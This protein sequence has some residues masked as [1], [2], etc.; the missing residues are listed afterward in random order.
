MRSTGRVV[1]GCVVV[2][3]G[4][5]GPVASEAAHVSDKAKVAYSGTLKG[6]GTDTSFYVG[7]KVTRNGNKLK[8]T[9]ITYVDLGRVYVYC[10]GVYVAAPL[11]NIKGGKV[12]GKK[13][14]VSRKVEELGRS[15]TVKV[16]G[17][18]KGAK[19]TK[20]VGNATVTLSTGCGTSGKLRW[21]ATY[22]TN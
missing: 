5:S 4:F 12:T 9:K 3:L 22:R 8:P 6:G 11:L 7:A 21:R 20:A 18:F 2:A 16:N 19:R 14:S 13:F 10:D 17:T 15:Y 1:A